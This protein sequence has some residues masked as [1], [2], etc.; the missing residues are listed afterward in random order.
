MG[1]AARIIVRTLV[2]LVVL[3]IAAG[4]GGYFYAKPLLLTATGYAAHNACAVEQL[5]DRSD[6]AQDLPPNPL[7][8][9]LRSY[10]DAPRTVTESGILGVLSKQKAWYTAGFGCTLAETRPSLPAPAEVTTDGNPYA[11]ADL[12]D[13]GTEAA[14]LVETAMKVPGTR[15]VVVLKRGQILAESYA[16]GFTAVTPQLGWSMAKSVTNLLAGRLALEG[17]VTVQD[18]GLRPEWTDSRRDIT[19]DDLLRGTSG[20]TWDET[21][22]LGT[23][24]TAMLYLEPDMAGFAAKQPLAHPPG[25]YQQYS[26]GATNILCATLADKAGV[27]GRERANLPRTLLFDP[28]GTGSAVWEPDAV[29]TPVCSSYLWATPRD[30]AAIGQFALQDGVWNGQRLLPEGWMKSSTTAKATP[31]SEEKGYAAAWWVNR[32]ADGTL[33]DSRW[34]ADTY[35]AQGHDGQRLVIVPSAQLVVV[36]LGFSPEVEAADLGVSELVASLVALAP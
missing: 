27:S 22:D 19:V 25:T 26:S 28:L 21:Y 15:G 33:V 4:V 35:W 13:T 7:V 14:A 18:K 29:G 1:R 32:Q 20:L 11:T 30:W 23:P 12:A 2:V 3:L 8:P 34:P 16:E 24:I 17:K 6:A 36:R 10:T 5:V 9:Y 31:Q